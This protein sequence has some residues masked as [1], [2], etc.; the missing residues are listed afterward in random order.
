MSE[1]MTTTTT[2]RADRRPKCA[3][4]D[5]DTIDNGE[6]YSV[7]DEVWAAAWAGRRLNCDCDAF[8]TVGG[9]QLVFEFNDTSRRRCC[10]GREILCIGCLE[11]RLGR[12]LTRADFTN[13]RINNPDEFIMSARL[14]S[15]LE[16][17]KA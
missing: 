11:R 13:C 7:H 15:R 12:T 2:G 8:D 14:R 3:D 10:Q 6:F 9:L 1:Q 17:G 4:C 5:V 16:S